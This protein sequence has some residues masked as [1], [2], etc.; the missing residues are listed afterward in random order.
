MECT[1]SAANFFCNRT[2]KNR[3]QIVG[4]E[5]VGLYQ[6]LEELI[7]FSFVLRNFVVCYNAKREI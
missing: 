7:G 3:W 2:F 5:K 1:Y 4:I 6:R